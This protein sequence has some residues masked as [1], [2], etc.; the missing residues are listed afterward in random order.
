[1]KP[2]VES[3]YHEFAA[4][5]GRFIS[6]RVSDPDTS[7]DI[8]Q[9]VFLRIHN[10]IDSLQDESKLRAWIYQITRNAII[11]YYRRRKVTAELPETLSYFDESGLETDASQELFPSIRGMIGHLPEKYRQALVMTEFQGLTQQ[12]TADRL[13]LSFSGAKSRVQ[14]AREQLKEMLLD[15]CHF[16]FDQLGKVLDYQPRQNCCSSSKYSRNCAS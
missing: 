2:D 11:D 15:C 6:S 14:R 12:E 4:Q 8:L 10:Q 1:M 16:E 13:G 5:L 9:D 7:E 3:V